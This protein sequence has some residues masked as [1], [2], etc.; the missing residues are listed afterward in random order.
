MTLTC[1]R[2]LAPEPL[3]ALSSAG[4]DRIVERYP[5]AEAAHRMKRVSFENRRWRGGSSLIWRWSRWRSRPVFCCASNSRS[6]PM[7][8]R[9]LA[10]SLPL[11]AVAK[12]GVFRGFGLRDLAWRYLGFSDLL[13]IAAAIWPLRG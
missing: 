11:A 13:R 10:V 12:L 6:G 4:R 7:Y 5:G 1:A 9:M 2:R 8:R 3:E